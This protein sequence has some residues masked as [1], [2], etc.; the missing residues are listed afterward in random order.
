[1]AVTKHH[2]RKANWKG[3]GLFSLHFQILVHTE[4]SQDRNSSR[5]G[6]WK[7][8]LMQRPWRGAAYWVASLGFLSLLFIE[9]RTTS[10]GMAP[11]TMGWAL[12]HQS[13]IKKMSYRWIL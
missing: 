7:Q 1:V 13:L 2:D 8:E 9:P 6:T 10:L 11:P 3:K 12:S 5:A 4:E